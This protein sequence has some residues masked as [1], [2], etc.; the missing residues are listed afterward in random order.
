MELSEKWLQRFEKEGFANVYD[1]SDSAGTEY[2]EHAHKGKVSLFVTD[3]S[4][5]FDFS[6]TKKVV[7]AG[8]RFDVPVGEP[9]SA[10]VGPEGWI[11]VVGEE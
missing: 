11:V 8:E 6:G 5:E 7:A 3:G 2:P 9:H 10:K 4:I 1:W